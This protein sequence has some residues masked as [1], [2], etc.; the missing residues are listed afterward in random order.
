MLYLRTACSDTLML[1]ER[2]ASMADR[3][4]RSLT[5]EF[6]LG[7]CFTTL[8]VRKLPRGQTGQVRQE[9]GA[10][11]GGNLGRFEEVE[12]PQ[13]VPAARHHVEGEGSGGWGVVTNGADRR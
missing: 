10:S 9:K 11:G 2:K 8:V 13:N 6:A 12:Q 4:F 7:P 5:G 3:S 1:R